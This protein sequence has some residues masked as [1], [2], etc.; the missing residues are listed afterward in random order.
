M[1][2]PNIITLLLAL[3]TLL[4]SCSWFY[5]WRKDKQEAK[6]LKKDNKQKDM[7]LSKMYVDEFRHHIINPLMREVT[8]LRNAIQRID[9][10]P[11]RANCPVLD[12]LQHKSDDD[13]EPKADDGSG[14]HRHDS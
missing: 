11:H 14:H 10:C 9:R 4:S 7:D 13:A 1:T 12:G 3:F 2:T 5:N 8:M 6:G